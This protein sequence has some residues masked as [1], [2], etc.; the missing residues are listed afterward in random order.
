MACRRGSNPFNLR[1]CMR[2]SS[3]ACAAASALAWLAVSSSRWARNTARVRPSYTSGDDGR[4]RCPRRASGEMTGTPMGS[5]SAPVHPCTRWSRSAPAEVDDTSVLPLPPFAFKNSAPS[6]CTCLS[7]APLYANIFAKPPAPAPAAPHC[8]LP[9]PVS[10]ASGAA[11][12]T[13]PPP[14]LNAR[15]CTPPKPVAGASGSAASRPAS[16]CRSRSSATACASSARTRASLAV[17]AYRR[18]TSNIDSSSCRR[19]ESQVKGSSLR[20]LAAGSLAFKLSATAAAAPTRKD[21]PTTKLRVTMDS[22]KMDERTAPF[23]PS[24]LDPMVLFTC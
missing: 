22:P 11:S 20:R 4:L 15:R 18:S 17:V 23:I 21:P 16:P 7:N 24:R 8:N 14:A 6:P 1:F 2:V 5:T 9:M 19:A 3:Q 13:N 12:A 10:G